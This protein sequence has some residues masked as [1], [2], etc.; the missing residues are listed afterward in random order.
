MNDETF[1]LAFV[2]YVF[3]RYEIIELAKVDRE[4]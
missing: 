4:V 3:S 2:V 1:F